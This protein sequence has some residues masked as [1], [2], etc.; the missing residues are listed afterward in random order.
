MKFSNNN[1]DINERLKEFIEQNISLIE[2]KEFDAL[3]RY[4]YSQPFDFEIGS[5]THMLYSIDVNP[6]E[7]LDYIP[8]DFFVGCDSLIEVEIPDH[9][10]YIHESAFYSCN[11]IEQI[12]IPKNVIEL[13]SWSI[14]GC[15]H[16]KKIVILGDLQR[17]DR[18]VFG[19]NPELKVI[20]CTQKTADLINN[21]P[22]WAEANRMR[23][24]KIEVVR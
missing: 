17:I 7:N 2:F 9:I 5:L 14:G 20:Y 16:L 19:Q 12:I 18:Y 6:L 11:N 1:P 10:E 8:I 22:E 3:Y 15:D 21:T 4:A 23:D 13:E 24:I